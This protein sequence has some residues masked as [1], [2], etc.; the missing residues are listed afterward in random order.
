[1]LN[2]TE[3]DLAERLTKNPALRINAQYSSR[4]KS[5]RK[6]STW[7]ARVESV[8]TEEAEQEKLAVILDRIGVWWCHVPNG[9]QRHVKVA[10]KLQKAGVKPGVPDILI[11]TPPPRMP[12]K[13][14]VAIEMKRRVGGS[15][16]EH[17]GEWLTEL[18]ALGWHTVVCRGYK[19][20]EKVLQE[21]GYME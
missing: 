7:A 9:G 4:P 15:V 3:A 2:W 21:C 1:M 6:S 17:Q 5:E 12:G 10:M 8:P 18:T 19:E 13:I 16:S 14:G 11:F 20:A